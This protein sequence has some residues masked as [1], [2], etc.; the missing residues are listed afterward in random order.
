MKTSDT[1][2]YADIKIGI[3]NLVRCVEMVPLAFVM[4][5]S[6]P[7]KD[8]VYRRDAE[9]HQPTSY[10]GGFLGFRAILGMFDPTDTVV[11]VVRAVKMVIGEDTFYRREY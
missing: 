11:G 8:Y 6:Y 9:A 3:P 4:A 2:T 5:W 1:L 7:V 10:Q